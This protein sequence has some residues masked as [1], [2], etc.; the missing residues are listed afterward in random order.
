VRPED[1]S[2]VKVAFLCCPTAYVAF[3]HTS[4]LP[5]QRPHPNARLF[6]Y[7]QR[8]H[9]L[10]PTQ[11]VFYDLDEPGDFPKEYNGWF[12]IVVADPPFLNEVRSDANTGPA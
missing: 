3:Q 10:N 6:E 2:E 5:G 12:D 11:Y 1:P 9:V 8:F 7:D 4:P